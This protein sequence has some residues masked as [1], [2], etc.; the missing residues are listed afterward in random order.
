MKFMRLHYN[1][2]P[3]NTERFRQAIDRIN[4]EYYRLTTVIELS[5]SLR[6]V[7][8]S[9]FDAAPGLIETL[10]FDELVELAHKGLWHFIDKEASL[11]EPY[12]RIGEYVNPQIHNW[13]DYPNYGPSKGLDTYKELTSEMNLDSESDARVEAK[14]E[15]F[16]AAIVAGIHLNIIQIDIP[17]AEEPGDDNI[18]D[19]GGEASDGSSDEN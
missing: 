16:T 5:R 14:I 11:K 10:D 1:G 4:E 18:E 19:L 8:T 2:Q 7:F 15:E 12:D 13:K 6:S 9:R 17:A 3:M